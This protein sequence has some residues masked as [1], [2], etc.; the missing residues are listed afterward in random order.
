MRFV[1]DFVIGPILAFLPRRW[2]NRLVA[3]REVQWVRAGSASGF[4]ELIAAVVAFGYWYIFEMARLVDAAVAEVVNKQIEG[5]TE[6]QITGMALTLFY[7]QPLTWVLLYFFFEGAVRLCSAA[8]TLQTFGTLPLA[9]VDWLISWKRG[10]RDTETR[11]G[12]SKSTESFVG[13]MRERV[14][15]A[16]TDE[17]ADELV[18]WK[19]GA[20]EI[21]EIR[22]NRRKVDWVPPKVVRMDDAYY[23]LEECHT[24]KTG[25]PFVY[26]LRKLPAGVPGRQVLIY[27]RMDEHERS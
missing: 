5:V 14:R 26:R 4:Y 8:F 2:R 16:I 23:R 1:W 22:T 9:I 25:R 3:A 6:H 19:D 27:Q 10:P 21:V 7:L 13:A 12:I 15:Q 11:D 24:A 18:S 17:L 20:K